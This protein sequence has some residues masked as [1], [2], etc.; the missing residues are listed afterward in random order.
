[1][2]NVQAV[3]SN[4]K[5]IATLSRALEERGFRPDMIVKKMVEIY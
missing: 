1:M 5:I 2:E 3:G 4:S